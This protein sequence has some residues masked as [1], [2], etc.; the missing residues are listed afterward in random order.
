VPRWRTMI[1]PAEMPAAEYLHSKT[2]GLGV[3]T[4][5]G[6]P[7]CFLVSIALSLYTLDWSGCDRVDSQLSEILPMA[8]VLLE[9]LAPLHLENRDFVMPSVP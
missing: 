2:L 1:A 7:A 3:A 5:A 8:G 4:V 9:V 6:R